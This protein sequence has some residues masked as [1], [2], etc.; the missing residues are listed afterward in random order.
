MEEFVS[1]GYLGT[2]GGCVAVVTIFTEIIK[3][4]VKNISPKWFVLIVTV[5]VI[6][7]R[8]ALVLSDISPH[9]ITE[10]F[11]NAGICLCAAT[12]LYEFA[13]KPIEE[14]MKK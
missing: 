13:F 9:G 4:Y 11:I 8:Q 3:K 7:L 2:L 10:A 5:I 6:A 1:L 14:G 12:G